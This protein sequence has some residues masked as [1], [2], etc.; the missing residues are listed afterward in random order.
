ME[1]TSPTHPAH[2]NEIVVA[3][4]QAADAEGQT[5]RTEEGQ[6]EIGG[7]SGLATPPSDMEVESA[8]FKWPYTRSFVNPLFL[9]Y[10]RVQSLTE[11]GKRGFA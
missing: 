7:E 5:E 1:S 10:L 8:L 2:P 9:N 6:A 3:E 4:E 11:T